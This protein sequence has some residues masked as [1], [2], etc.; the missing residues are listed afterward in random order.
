MADWYIHAIY[1]TE[2]HAWC[3]LD[4]D[5]PGLVTSGASIEELRERASAILPDLLELNAHELPPERRTGPHNLR[6]V[7]FH[8]S[9][10]PVAA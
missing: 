3:T 6:I 2:A 4:T 8:E 5:I 9:I 10:A 7:A 1:D